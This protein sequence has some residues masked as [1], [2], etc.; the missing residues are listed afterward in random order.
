VNATLIISFDS[1]GDN[2]DTV[3]SRV[4]LHENDTDSEI[5]DADAESAESP[6]SAGMEE[7][8]MQTDISAIL[9]DAGND[10]DENRSSLHENDTD[11]R[12]QNSNGE[13]TD[14]GQEFMSEIT[15][16]ILVQ[17]VRSIVS[18]RSLWL[19]E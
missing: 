16:R 8:D 18:S 4:H 6:S 9:L 13:S 17:T 2:G 7:G 15:D 12:I 10:D 1:E 5:E 3:H 19:T 11:P 14:A